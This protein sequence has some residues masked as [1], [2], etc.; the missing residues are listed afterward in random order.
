MRQI[1]FLADIE[2]TVTVGGSLGGTV[3]PGDTNMTVNCTITWAGAAP[4]MDG[5]KQKLFLHLQ[6]RNEC[7]EYPEE[8]GD[9]HVAWLPNQ[10]TSISL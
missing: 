1:G 10:Q 6:Q 4:V 8:P 7:H 9:L 5:G 3:D 2:G